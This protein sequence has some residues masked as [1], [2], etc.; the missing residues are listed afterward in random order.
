MANKIK[1][2]IACAF[3]SVILWGIASGLFYITFSLFKIIADGLR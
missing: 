2:L 3:V 1:V